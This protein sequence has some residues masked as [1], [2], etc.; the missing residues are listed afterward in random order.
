MKLA[1]YFIRYDRNAFY[2]FALEIKQEVSV[3]EVNSSVVGHYSEA[4][5]FGDHRQVS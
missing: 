4:A 3:A 1:K 5:K 2:C